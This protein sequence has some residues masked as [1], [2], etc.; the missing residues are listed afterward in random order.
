MA[1]W[2]NNRRIETAG[3][4]EEAKEQLENALGMEVDETGEGEEGFEG[5]QKTLGAL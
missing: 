2:L 4:E 5:T 1:E 3:T